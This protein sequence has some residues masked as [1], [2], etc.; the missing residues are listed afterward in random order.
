MPATDKKLK[1]IIS[2]EDTGEGIPEKEFAG[3]ERAVRNLPPGTV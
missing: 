2:V 3:K 1:L